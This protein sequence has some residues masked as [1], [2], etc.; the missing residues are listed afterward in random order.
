MSPAK[1]KGS[2][3]PANKPVI[4]ADFQSRIPPL[5]KEEAKLL[6]E[7]II[8]EGC[9]EPLIVWCD[10]LV[11]GQENQMNAISVS[12]TIFAHLLREAGVAKE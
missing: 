3:A 8:A 10:R 5:T 7:S 1:K 6:E 4:D 2:K 11:D 12:P 9:R